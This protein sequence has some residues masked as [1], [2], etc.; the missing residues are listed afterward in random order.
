[1]RAWAKDRVPQVDVDKATEQFLDHHR[2]KGSVMADWRAAWMTWMRNVPRYG[3]PGAPDRSST[4][5][6][7]ERVAGWQDLKEGDRGGP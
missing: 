3:G 1:M 7:D 4:S 5:P 6:T 2:A